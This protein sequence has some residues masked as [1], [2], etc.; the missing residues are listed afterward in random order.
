MLTE[1]EVIR[2]QKKKFNTKHLGNFFF[3]GRTPR[4]KMVWHVCSEF[5]KERRMSGSAVARGYKGVTYCM[6]CGES[7]NKTEY[8][9]FI[10][11]CFMLGVTLS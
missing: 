2:Y 5:R 9:A 3:I 11:M 7:L 4:N 6:M 10:K 1:E 8:S